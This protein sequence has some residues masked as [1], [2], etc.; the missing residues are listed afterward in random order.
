VATSGSFVSAHAILVTWNILF[1]KGEG[2]CVR[3]KYAHKVLRQR[4]PVVRAVSRGV[5]YASA[6]IERRSSLL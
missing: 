6:E 2:R 5:R 3:S 4:N 1:V